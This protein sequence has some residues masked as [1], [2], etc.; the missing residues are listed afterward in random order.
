M[1][2]VMGKRRAGGLTMAAGLRLR[3]EREESRKVGVDYVY[4]YVGPSDS[5]NGPFCRAWVGKCVTDPLAIFLSGS[6]SLR[7]HFY[8]GGQGCRH[9]WASIPTTVALENG[10]QIFETLNET[11]PRDITDEMR[12]A[13][14]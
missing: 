1:G 6:S 11:L 14:G 3:R 8:C 9:S 4:L 13:T 5:K 7:G 10:Y 2:A 12:A